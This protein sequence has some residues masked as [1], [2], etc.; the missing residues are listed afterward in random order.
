MDQLAG[1]Y[2]A[3]EREKKRAYEQ[4][5]QEV[6]HSSFTPLVLSATGGTGNEATTFFKCLASLLA[7]K[8]DSHY[9]STLYWLRCRLSFSLPVYT[10]T[11]RIRPILIPAARALRDSAR[12]R[13]FYAI[14][15]SLYCR[16]GPMRCNLCTVTVAC[17]HVQDLEE[18]G[19]EPIA[20][21]AR[22]QKIKPRPSLM[23]S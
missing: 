22:A 1:M 4:R 23:R 15:M 19:V 21:E 10:K 8:W 12:P 7:E 20:R 2:R 17:R 9:S 3:H 11:P 18:G 14:S 6:E 16:R 5:V 13:T